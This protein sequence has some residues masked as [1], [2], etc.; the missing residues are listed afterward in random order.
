MIR[1]MA[2]TTSRSSCAI[3]TRRWSGTAGTSTDAAR[4][5]G[6]DGVDR[7]RR[8]VR[9]PL[10]RPAA[11]GRRRPARRLRRGRQGGAR[12]PSCARRRRRPGSG[13]LRM[14][15]PSGNQLEIVDYRDVQFSKT[16]A[17][18]RGMGCRRP[19]EEH[20]APAELAA[21][22]ACSDATPRNR[23]SCRS[24][25]VGAAA[26]S[27]SSRSYP[28]WCRSAP[29]SP[30]SASPGRL[31]ARAWAIA[32]AMRA[33]CC[34]AAA[35]LPAATAARHAQLGVGEQD[36][37]GIESVD[38]HAGAACPR[39]RRCRRRTPPAAPPRTSG[40]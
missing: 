1:P 30:C 14:R 28:W 31:R 13:S 34:A 40:P 9:G 20:S 18:L 33:K 25:V 35:S 16:D 6:D 29:V 21:R 11:G 27:S 2:S 15:D 36:E 32:A 26:R 19:R 5:A 38:G 39:H 17:V 37:L 23:S 4:P 24:V 12:A 10:R 7:S 22:R 3:S 8:P